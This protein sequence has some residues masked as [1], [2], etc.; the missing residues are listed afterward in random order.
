M[1]KMVSISSSLLFLCLTFVVGGGAAITSNPTLSFRVD[2]TNGNYSVSVDNTVW[3]ASPLSSF[4]CVAGNQNVA[5]QLQGVSNTNGVDNFGE[6]T[7][8][9]ADYLTTDTSKSSVAY[10]FKQYTLYSNVI[11]FTASFPQGLDTSGCGT[12]VQ[13]STQF[14]S[15]DTSQGLANSLGFLTFRG[16]VLEDTASATG[17]GSLKNTAE[18]D[19]GPIVG[20]PL[21]VTPSTPGIVLSTLDNHKIVVQTTTVPPTPGPLTALWSS[22]RQD[23]IACLSQLCTADQQ[24]GGNYTTQRIEG[25]GMVVDSPFDTMDHYT[26]TL[27]G[28]D[29]SA[30][31]L[32][33]AYSATETDNWV[34]INS[35]NPD[36]TY[37]FSAANGL[38]FSDNSVP[39]T[40]PLQVYSKTYGSRTDY[41]AVASAAGIQWATSAGYTFRYTSGYVWATA[42]SSSLASTITVSS[43]RAGPANAV[44]SLGV[45]ASI[46]SLPVGYNYSVLMT[47]A[48]GG[49]VATTYAW[50][51]QI[52]TYYNTYRVDSITLKNIG[53]YTDDGAYYYVWEAFNIPAR[54]WAAEDGLLQIIQTLWNQSVPI[55]YLQLDDWW[56]QGPFYFGNV[57]AVVNWTAS[58]VPRLFPNG[59][60][61][62]AD[63]LNLPLQLYTPFWDDSFPTP[64]NMT[65]STVFK[66]T[67]LVTPEDSYAFF[68]DLFDFGHA[69][70]NGR[71]STYEI[72][73]L[74]SN[75][76]GSADMFSSV[77]AADQWYHGMADAALERGIAIQYCLPSATDM[78]ES[79]TL[80][81][82]VQARASGD[83]VNTQANAF[84]IG[85]S[86]LFMGA[87]KMAPSKDTLW[88]ASPQPPTYSDTHQ[89][90]DYTTQ[91]HVQLDCMLATMSLGPVGISDGIGQTDV[92]LISQAYL[93]NT[94]GTLLRPARPISWVD[95]VFVNRSLAGGNTSAAQDIRSTHASIPTVRGGSPDAPMHNS[96]YVLSWETANDVVLGQT[97]LYPLPNP[98]LGLAVRFHY[99]T[100][101]AYQGC[102]N[103]S[104]AS[105]CVTILPPGVMPTI[106]ATGTNISNANLTVIY[107][108]LS[109]G[110]YFLGELN[111]FVHVSSQRFDYILVGSQTKGSPK[112]TVPPGPSGIIVGVKGTPGQSLTLVAIDSSQTVHT[113]TVTIPE[114]GF[115]DVGL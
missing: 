64:Y 43:L 12:N 99:L 34:G 90:G 19:N 52:Q 79:L 15:F 26:I 17:L 60:P 22:E 29:Y 10:I 114:S 98:S 107:E 13:G 70:T 87:V 55:S 85:G 24:N 66:N 91:P 16:Q 9:T 103:N 82:V 80:P 81:A 40:V 28:T 39:N 53:Y 47:A 104:V 67:K 2:T 20:F 38:I 105:S 56:Y 59:L 14:P 86:A 33:F 92:A 8:I 51:K 71:F 54:P 21:P 32:R 46:P 11:V 68:S 30:T 7:G 108:P 63:K 31:P 102:V 88:T 110:A 27:D 83:Y 93:S 113:Q 100:G 109:N 58:P 78:L 74:D 112:D 5:L 3:F 36:S 61:A 97:D 37:T 94:D 25:Y 41:A 62:F 95:S 106:P 76:A 4:I 73:F 72:D 57:K 101:N 50:G 84:Q 48:Y 77:Y 89:N 111:K 65:E 44:Y 6:W 23:Q 42:P 96:H 49:P 75:F 1:Y 18:L 69:Q 45:A 35:T 115:I